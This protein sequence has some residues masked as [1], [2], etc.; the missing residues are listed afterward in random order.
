MSRSTIDFGIDLGTT[1]S[2]IAVLQGKDIHVFKNNESQEYTPSAVWIDRNNQLFVG[3]AARERLESDPNNAFSEFKLQMGKQ[4]AY[5]FA[6][7]GREMKPEELSAEVLKSLKASVMQRTQEDIKAA[8]ITVPAAFELHQNEATRK[9][10]LLAGL[11]SSPLLQ[12]PVAAALAYGFQSRSDKVFWLVY[13]LGGG[14]FDAAV[15]QVR[16]GE[17]KVV[18]HGGDNHLGG[19]LIDWAIV[20]E[21]FIPALTQQYKLSDFRRGN[22]AWIAAIAK[23]KAEAEQAKIGLSDHQSQWINIPF[24]GLSEQKQP[25]AFEYE[26]KRSDVER[27]AEPFILRSINTCKKVLKEKNL[28]TGD[29]EKILLVGGPTLTPYLRERLVD[30]RTGLGIPIDFSIDP[31]TVVA[32]GA[33]IF[34]GTQRIAQDEAKLENQRQ[35]GIY[36]ISFPGW[37]FQGADSETTVGGII[38]GAREQSFQGY[39]VEFVNSKVRPP[40]RSGQVPVGAGGSFLTTLWVKQGEVNTYVVELRDPSGRLCQSIT[41]PSE[42]SYTVGM[43]ISNI[44]LTHS[45]GVALANNEVEWFLEKGRALPARSQR[46]LRTAFEVHQGQAGDVVR[47]PVV[48]GESRRADRN[49]VIGKLEVS[50]QQVRRSVPVGTEVGITIDIDASRLLRTKANIPLLDEEFEEVLHLGGEDSAQDVGKL[51]EEL[52]EQ[53]K[54]LQRLKR[55]TAFSEGRNASTTEADLLEQI[56]KEQIVSD[57]ENAFHAAETDPE[58]LDVGDKRLRDLKKALD[59]AEAALE[60]P[61][62]VKQAED[63]IAWAREQVDTYG[64]LEDRRSFQHGED[65]IQKAI[66]TKN[67]DVLEVR[68]GALRKAI[69]IMLDRNDV[70]PYLRF[71]YLCT[72]SGEMHNPAQVQRLIEEGRNATRMQNVQLLRSINRQLEI[73]LPVPPPPLS[74]GTLIR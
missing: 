17:I 68:I 28:T 4:T 65:E 6:F 40:W 57:A 66:Q 7:S 22:P 2:V 52:E 61:N 27:L 31:L 30:K 60:W 46:T 41:D 64:S 20:E 51:Q 19:K 1:N 5:R 47:I 26:L 9:A 69:W 42:L 62:L 23:L 73:L 35:Q 49:R 18:N 16:D 25:I 50:A 37:T 8:V 24:L 33:A 45:I 14:T 38:K 63:I 67:A 34:A 3:R 74:I 21:L 70:L 32:R 48:E 15:M 39:T 71:E 59:E 11:T 36:T 10:A 54:R 43:V 55:Q 12:E 72:Q 58:S 13:D 44:P 53:K 29:V 56:E